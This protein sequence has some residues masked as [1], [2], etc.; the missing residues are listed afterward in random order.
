M[1]R[2]VPMSPG[3][4]ARAVGVG[5]T[6]LIAGGLSAVEREQQLDE[7]AGLYA[8]RTDVRHRFA[9]LGDHPLR[10]RAEL[11]AHF[12]RAS[13]LTGR[14]DRFEQVDIV[15]HT[16]G[17]PEV[18]IVQYS[19]RISREGREYSAPAIH[20]VRVR[21]GEIVESRDYAHHIELARA[22]GRLGELAE[23]LANAASP[24]S[25]GSMAHSG[26]GMSGS[27]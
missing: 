7:L 13:A 14:P 8:E 22:M 16:T 4:V 17:D 9:P 19:Y 23:A 5:A 27:R 1:T 6:R 3:Q 21:D 20:V 15:I 11:R 2:D 25:D 10:T 24:S 26:S 18:V 12:A